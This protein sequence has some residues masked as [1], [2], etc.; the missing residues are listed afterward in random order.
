LETEVQDFDNET[1]I[2]K[3]PPDAIPDLKD[4]KVNKKVN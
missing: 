2:P 3:P 4:E 1:Y